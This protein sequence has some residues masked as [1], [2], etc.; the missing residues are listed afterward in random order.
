V[1]AICDADC[2]CDSD[3]HAYSYTDGD[4]NGDINTYG[5]SDSDRDPDS[6]SHGHP[7]AHTLAD[8]G[9]V[10]GYSGLQHLPAGAWVRDFHADPDPHAVSDTNEYRF[11]FI[12]YSV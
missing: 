3:P 8:G 4:I 9:R 12:V 7:N 5:H 1:C 10:R 6:D 2:D 11:I